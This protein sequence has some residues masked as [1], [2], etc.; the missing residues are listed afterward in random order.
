MPMTSVT[1]KLR[2]KA[3]RSPRRMAH[4]PNWH[5]NDEMISRIVAG[6]TNGR[7]EMWNGSPVPGS[8]G[9]HCGASARRLK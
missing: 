7:I 6:P 3:V 1:P 5:V 8:M 4:T 9:G 2:R